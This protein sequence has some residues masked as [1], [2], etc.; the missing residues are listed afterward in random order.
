MAGVDFPTGQELIAHSTM[1]LRYMHFSSDHQQCAVR[2]LD[3]PGIKS[4]Q[5]SQQLMSGRLLSF[6]EYFIF[7]VGPLAQLAEQR[8]LNP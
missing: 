6:H 8:T 7:K 1:T 3:V 2:A 5:S 4:Q